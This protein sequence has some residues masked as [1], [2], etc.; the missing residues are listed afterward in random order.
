MD[1]LAVVIC[2]KENR[3]LFEEFIGWDFENPI[4]LD[5][6]EIAMLRSGSPGM[7]HLD[8]DQEEAEAEAAKYAKELKTQD[9]DML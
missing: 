4:H 7:H 8:Q 5:V 3:E 9:K 2:C 6:W 1:V